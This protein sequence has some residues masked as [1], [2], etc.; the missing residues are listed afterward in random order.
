[1]PQQNNNNNNN[2]AT[3][4]S[5]RDTTNTI[6]MQIPIPNHSNFFLKSNLNGETQKV[7]MKFPRIFL[8]IFFFEVFFQNFLRF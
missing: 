4:A 5:Y 2:N 3:I 7:Y 6:T 1:M 8:K